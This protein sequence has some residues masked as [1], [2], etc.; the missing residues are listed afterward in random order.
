MCRDDLLEQYRELCEGWRHDDDDFSRF[1]NIFFALSVVALT[2]PYLKGS[3]VPAW[4]T[5]VLGLT[6]MTYWFFMGRNFQHRMDIRWERIHEI[7]CKLCY[8]VHRR[9]DRKRT[10]HGN[11][12]YKP[13]NKI[14]NKHCRFAI[15]LIY[16]VAAIIVII[17]KC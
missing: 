7:E 1:T 12:W 17:D 8:D 3:E 5:C 6:G 16:I 4:L 13:W 10:Q 2:A 14:R 9:I 11:I 15:W